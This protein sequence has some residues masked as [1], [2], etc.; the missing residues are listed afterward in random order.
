MEK[1]GHTVKALE[2]KPRIDAWAWIWQAWSEMAGD[3]ITSMGNGATSWVSIDAYARRYGIEDDDFELFAYGIR[4]LDMK[5]LTYVQDEQKR[6]DEE[7]R[8]KQKAAA[9][10]S[11]GKKRKR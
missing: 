4:V 10:Q 11:K 1:E 5:A 2:A 7:H 6:K 8:R 9:K 3:R